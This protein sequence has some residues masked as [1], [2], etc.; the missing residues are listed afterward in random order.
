MPISEMRLGGWTIGI[1][2]GFSFIFMALSDEQAGKNSN[3]SAQC[4]PGR[5]TF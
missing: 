5:S 4:A 3:R 2:I 1:Q